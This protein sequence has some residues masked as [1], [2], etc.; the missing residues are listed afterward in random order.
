[1]LFKL[2]YSYLIY[3]YQPASFSTLKININKDRETR[4]K[5]LIRVQK[6][7]QY[8]AKKKEV[9]FYDP[10]LELVRKKKEKRRNSG[11][12]F[13]EK[14]SYLKK[15]EEMRKVQTAKHLGIDLNKEQLTVEEENELLNPELL[16]QSTTV[17]NLPMKL[18][19]LV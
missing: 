13:A 19:P 14:G 16:P 8:N 17:K 4:V 10:A 11:F 5:E 15:A 1:M 12:N 7:D 9:K 2:K 6:N 18:K 3:I